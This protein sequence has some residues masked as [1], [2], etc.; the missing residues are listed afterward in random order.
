VLGQVGLSGKTQFPHIHLSVRRN[1]LVVDPFAPK[2]QPACDRKSQGLWAS[3]LDY[4]PTGIL[5]AGFTT[6]I[7]S[8]AEVKDGPP[9]R[10]FSPMDEALVL[11]VYAFGARPGDQLRLSIQGP[12]GPFLNQDV[13]LTKTQAQ[14]FRAVGKRRPT[15]GF[16]RGRYTGQIS[17]MRKDQKVDRHQ[18]DLLVE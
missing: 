8:F 3:P 6:R 7:P 9:A 11:W 15:G 14:Y 4:A 10:V 5:N 12:T 1:G 2:A 16:Q 13:V 17:L 18:I